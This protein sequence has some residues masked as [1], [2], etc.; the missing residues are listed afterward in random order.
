LREEI[1]RVLQLMRKGDGQSVAFVE[2]LAP[3][4]VFV[5]ADEHALRQL[6]LNLLINAREAVAEAASPEIRVQL[7]A[8]RGE[9]E[10]HILDNGRGIASQDLARIFDPFFTTKSMGTGLGLAICRGISENLG[11]TISVTSK[12]GEGTEVVVQLPRTENPGQSGNA[13]V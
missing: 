13:V 12:V 11:G 7:K 3:D 8:R 6:F 2:D 5:L 4:P 9:A 10:I 1:S